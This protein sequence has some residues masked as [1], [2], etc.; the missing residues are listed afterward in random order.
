MVHKTAKTN[1]LDQGGEAAPIPSS[2]REIRK[3][4]NVIK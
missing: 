2:E 3:L 4:F 1:D